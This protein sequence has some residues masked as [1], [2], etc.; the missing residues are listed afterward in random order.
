MSLLFA[1]CH[2]Q[3]EWKLVWEESFDNAD[4]DTAV[5]SMI[6]QGEFSRQSTLSHDER[7]Y[8]M[9]DG[10]LI[11]RGIVNEGFQKDSSIYLTGGIWTKGKQPGKNRMHWAAK[12]NRSTPA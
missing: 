4:L 8:Q 10:Q 6:P 12:Q 2:H 9:R 3:P 11:L 1:S 7:C 5:W